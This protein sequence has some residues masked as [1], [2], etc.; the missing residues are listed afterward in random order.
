MN[1]PVTAVIAMIGVVFLVI[2]FPS[3]LDGVQ[4]AQ[5]DDITDSYN[6]TTAAAVTNATVT[7]SQ[8]LFNDH[9]GHVTTL[10]SDGGGGDNPLPSSYT[11]AGRALLITG[12]DAAKTRNVTVAYRT[13]GVDEFTG[14][15]SA[16]PIIPTIGFFAII[17]LIIGAL[18]SVFRKH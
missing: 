12:L 18:I 16:L 15:S 13:D 4:D 10:S 6:V 17:V 7:L 1:K 2:I 11:S 3:F 5:T 14:L 8:P 9:T